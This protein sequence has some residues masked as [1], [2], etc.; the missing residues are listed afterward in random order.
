MREHWTLSTCSV[1]HEY[2][3]VLEHAQRNAKGGYMLRH[4]NVPC[5]A[6]S[7]NAAPSHIGMNTSSQSLTCPAT[8]HAMHESEYVCVG[9]LNALVYD[10]VSCDALTCWFSQRDAHAG[11]EFVKQGF[12]LTSTIKVF[13]IPYTKAISYSCINSVNRIAWTRNILIRIG[14]IKTWLILPVVICLYQRLSHACVCI[15]WHSMKLWIA[16]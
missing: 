10:P 1:P 11:A 12:M 14:M 8:C 7:C 5:T 4:R 13:P 6:I 15:H 3:T 9:S 16:H 2:S